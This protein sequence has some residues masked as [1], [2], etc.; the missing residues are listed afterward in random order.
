MIVRYWQSPREV[1][2]FQRQLDRI[3]SEFN[4]ADMNINTTWT[5]AINLI[6][7]GNDLLLQVQLP[8]VSSEHIDIQASREA[9]VISGQRQMPQLPEGHRLLHSELSYGTFRRVVSLP[10]AIQNTQVAASFE[11]GFLS[12]TLPKV[13][14]VRNRVVKISLDSPQAEAPAAIAEATAE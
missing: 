10:I 11:H 8:G 14:E 12:L 7:Q 13:E 4:S 6:D 3:F 2:S 5:P 9:V 1:E